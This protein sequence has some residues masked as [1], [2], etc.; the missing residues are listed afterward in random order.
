MYRMEQNQILVKSKTKTILEE[1]PI[2]S[3][4]SY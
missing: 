2:D 4:F 3:Y 1:N